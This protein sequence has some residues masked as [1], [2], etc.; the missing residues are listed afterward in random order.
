M[1]TPQI[2]LTDLTPPPRDGKCPRCR[3]DERVTVAGFGPPREACKVCGYQFPE[4][5]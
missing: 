5:E 3:G 1:T 4:G 2:V